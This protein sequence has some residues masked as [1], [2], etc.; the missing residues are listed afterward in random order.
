M[1]KFKTLVEDDDLPI[2]EDLSEIL[3]GQVK[4][5]WAQKYKFDTEMAVL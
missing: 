2:E 4:T 5:K 1:H 3:Y